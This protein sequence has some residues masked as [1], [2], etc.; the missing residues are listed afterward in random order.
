MMPLRSIIS[1]RIFNLNNVLGNT[2]KNHKGYE[3]LNDWRESSILLLYARFKVSCG[4]DYG[5]NQAWSAISAAFTIISMNC[6]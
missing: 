5:K 3:S 4:H 1:A 6:S 2:S